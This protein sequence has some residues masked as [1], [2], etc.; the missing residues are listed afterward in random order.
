MVAVTL[1]SAEN[2]S[3]MMTPSTVS[4]LTRSMPCIV[5]GGWARES[6]PRTPGAVM[7]I[8]IVTWIG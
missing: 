7:T 8:S 2:R 4:L 5:D 6:A 3:L 1:L